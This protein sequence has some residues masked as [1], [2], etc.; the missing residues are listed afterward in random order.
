[1]MRLLGM[2]ECVRRHPSVDGC[3]SDGSGEVKFKNA[4]LSLHSHAG[5]WERGKPRFIQ[6]GK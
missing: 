4:S 5:A 6:Q 3:K 1:M 2:T